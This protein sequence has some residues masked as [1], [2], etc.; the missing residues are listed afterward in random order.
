MG[1]T[2]DARREMP[3]WDAPGFDG[4]GVEP[5]DV[6]DAWTAA[7]A[8]LSRRAGPARRWSCRRSA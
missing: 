2:Y 7:V 1:E 4:R 6:R 5:V 8:G 3:G